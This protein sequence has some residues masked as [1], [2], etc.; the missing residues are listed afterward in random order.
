MPESVKVVLWIVCL[1][2][3]VFTVGACLFF[4]GVKRNDCDGF[5]T[6]DQPVAKEV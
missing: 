4:H 5:G 6:L 2:S 3:I 1:C